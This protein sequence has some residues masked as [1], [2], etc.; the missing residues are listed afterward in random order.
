[1]N[2]LV[3]C[4]EKLLNFS[5]DGQ[6]D[7][8]K[9]IPTSARSWSWAIDAAAIIVLLM[10]STLLLFRLGHYALW[11]DEASTGIFAHNVW[12]FGDTY[13]WDGTNIDAY[14]NGL[15]LTGIKNRVFPP[16]QFFF[17]APFLGLLG[18]TA[19]AA[20]LPFALAGIGGFTLWWWWLRR[21]RASIQFCL[22]TA[23]AVLGNVS[24]FLYSRQARYYALAWALSLAFVYLYV[25]RDESQTKR[26]IFSLCGIALLATNYF[27][28]GAMMICLCI[29]YLIFE[30]RQRRDTR[31]QVF[32]FL[33]VQ[34]AGFCVIVGIWYPFGRQ[35]FPSYVAASWITDKL[36][37]FWWNLR[38]LNA[39]EFMWTPMLVVALLVWTVGG[40]RDVWLIRSILAVII[41]AAVIS[42][43]APLPVEVME[44]SYATRY[45]VPIIPLGVFIS[46]RV[47]MAL[48]FSFMPT[49]VILATFLFLTSIPY[50]LFQEAVHAPTAIPIRST[51][52]SWIGELIRPQDQAYRVASAWLNANAKPLETVYVLPEFAMYP[53]MFHAPQQV[54][55]WQFSPEK[56]DEY[57]ALPAANFK[58]AIKPDIVVVFGSYGNYD[59]DAVN[60][61][62]AAGGSQYK[63]IASLDV[64]GRDQT[65]P[66]L[67]WHSFVTIPMINPNNGINVFRRVP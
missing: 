52:I 2:S 21:H 30:I 64:F 42:I 62:M 18:R 28:Y 17:A 13:A 8:S 33:L 9:I 67:F 38:D 51:L 12:K 39:G 66:E 44:I 36:T 45:M 48:P 25:H 65:R 61:I 6:M 26:I 23:I 34:S 35:L 47:L 59:A 29:D 56:R 24:L 40:F 31:F 11:D 7:Q 57:P 5:D 19:F 4:A 37:L 55:A 3:Q 1:V 60:Q 14:G 53:L 15:E 10:C 20:R 43:L 49:T 27:A 54:Y 50:A 32:M 58:G 46:V 41:Y 63:L 16:A 22:L